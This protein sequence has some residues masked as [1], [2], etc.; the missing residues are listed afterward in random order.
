MFFVVVHDITPQQ[1]EPLAAIIRQLQPLVG[2]NLSAAVVP[3][4]QG[5]PL[6]KAPLGF[7]DWVKSHFAEILLHG[8]THQHPGAG[9]PV[10]WLTGQSNEFTGLSTSAAVE[11]LQRGQAILTECFGQP[12]AGFVPPAWQWGPIN[13]ELLK[14]SGLRYGVGM[15]GIYYVDG[16]RA[17]LA[18]WSWDAGVCAPL[19]YAG[20]ALGAVR[21]KLRKEA[22]PC[23]VFHPLDVERGF[24][25]RGIQLIEKNL[26]AG[27]KP[28]SLRLDLLAH[29]IP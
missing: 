19:G 7:I 26:S 16:R 3:C 15:A 14:T 23:L 6:R 9:G 13:L 17:P 5:E 10:G 8:C 24:V 29:S 20:E 4:W 21:F 12:A 11:R 25:S 27:R 1:W 22:I 28:M 2:Q 18:T